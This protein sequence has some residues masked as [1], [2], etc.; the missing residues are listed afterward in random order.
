M[1]I[2]ITGANGL[3]EMLLK[4]LKNK[5]LNIDI[6]GT[7]KPIISK[8]FNKFFNIE[9]EKDRKESLPIKML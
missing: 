1:N 5:N 7:K 2:L 8:G 4:S 9:I 6:L 3:L